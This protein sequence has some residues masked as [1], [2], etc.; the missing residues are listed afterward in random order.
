M[1][2]LGVELKAGFLEKSHWITMWFP[3]IWTWFQYIQPNM[4]KTVK[5]GT[6]DWTVQQKFAA[7]HGGNG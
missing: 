1:L 4:E 3:V 7:G 5:E 2:D 6:E